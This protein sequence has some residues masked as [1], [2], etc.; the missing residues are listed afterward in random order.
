MLKP[1][2]CIIGYVSEVLY[3]VGWTR[4]LQSN[5][6]CS[7]FEVTAPYTQEADILSPHLWI[8]ASNRLTPALRRFRVTHS[9]LGK[10]DPGGAVV[11]KVSVSCLGR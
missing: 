8:S 3:G 7:A 5:K 9:F 6:M 10:L 11:S 2:L 4:R 1:V